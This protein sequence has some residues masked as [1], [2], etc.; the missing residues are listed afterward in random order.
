MYRGSMEYLRGGGG[1]RV[2]RRGMTERLVLR[3]ERRSSAMG[4][5]EPF[6]GQV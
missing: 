2:N 1:D 4:N 3:C 5:H 6:K